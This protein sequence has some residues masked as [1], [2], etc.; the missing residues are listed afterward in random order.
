MAGEKTEKPTH[1]RI[2]D[3]RDKG[4]VPRSRDLVGACSLLAVTGMLAWLGPHVISGLLARLTAALQQLGDAPRAT[5]SVADLTTTARSDAWRLVT[6]VGPL[7]L[8]A[9]VTAVAANFGQVGWVF[10]P[11][12]LQLNWG[13]MNPANGLKR[14]VPSEA[15]VNV[16]KALLAVVTLGAI[17]WQLGSALTVQA[18]DLV[19]MAPTALGV[20]AWD[21]MWRL[22]A[23][24]GLA[25]LVFAGADYA[26]QRWRTMTN[27][28]MS[29]QDV[30]D[31]ARSSEGSPEI[32]SRVRRI[33]REMARKRMLTAVKRATVVIANPTHVSVAIEYRRDT[34]AAPV[35]VAKGQDHLAL[36][37]RAIARENG[38]PIVENIAL[39]RALYKTADVG[40]MIPASLFGAIAE[41]LAYLVRIKQLAL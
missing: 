21:V 29:R 16:L 6:L 19:N 12:A 39:A 11:Q 18:T 4:Q 37:I 35:V 9:A 7:T 32:K 14:L 10:A 1:R 34:M 30:K 8:A 13:R 24:A 15:G 5:L 25:L 41:V 20:R 33:Q 27:L 17:G 22:V 3:A 26:V 23:R 40:D 28:K 38:V 36:R 31:E 2:K